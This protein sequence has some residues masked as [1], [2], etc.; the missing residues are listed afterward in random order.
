MEN[1]S[2]SV[3]SEYRDAVVRDEMEH[4]ESGALQ[5]LTEEKWNTEVRRVVNSS[6]VLYQQ[7]D[8]IKRV[9]QRF[10][11]NGTNEVREDDEKFKSEHMPVRKNIT[12][13]FENHIVQIHKHAQSMS[14]TL[15]FFPSQ[16]GQHQ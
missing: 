14:S 4:I 15:F 2:K 10:N 7:R 8:L 1:Y 13:N 3:R 16:N 11:W 5:V 9:K 12:C 6:M